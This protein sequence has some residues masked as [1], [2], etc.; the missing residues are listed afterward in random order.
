MQLKV[1][2]NGLSSVVHNATNHVQINDLKN[3][4]SLLPHTLPT[5]QQRLLVSVYVHKDYKIENSLGV[6]LKYELV[7]LF[8]KE[9]S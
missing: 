6:N 7:K 8:E 1:T 5:N 4:A 2:K 3:S 9:H